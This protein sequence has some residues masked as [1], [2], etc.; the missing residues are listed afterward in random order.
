MLLILQ[1][2][3]SITLPVFIAFI[4]AINATAAPILT[5][6]DPVFNFGIRD[7]A[8]V[9]T[10]SF[11]LSN[12]GDQ[13]LLITETKESCGCTLSE[14]EKKHI[15]P[16][17]HTEIRIM[18]ALKGMAGP[19]KKHVHIISNDPKRVKTITLKGTAMAR[20]A[21]EPP[22]LSMGRINPNSP[23]PPMQVNLTGYIT[24][25]IIT[26]ISCNTNLFR[27]VKNQD[28]RSFTVH[29]PENPPQGACKQQVI[30]KSSDNQS[31][32]LVMSVFAYTTP[33]IRF[34]PR[35]VSV[36][37]DSENAKRWVMLKPGSA[38]RFKLIDTKLSS[39]FASVKVDSRPNS[40][41][42]VVLSEIKPDL[43]KPNSNIT[44]IT[45]NSEQSEIIIPVKVLN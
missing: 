36:P 29:P 8:S 5:I 21:L 3:R 34:V 23:P 9:V 12:T 43:I 13:P 4:A 16:G 10:N 40:S 38:G 26:E 15:P 44:L 33:P 41:Y 42:H 6:K 28:S 14:I 18:M 22:A 35:T 2:G 17:E 24:N 37:K 19:V 45:D 39:P 31:P 27:V 20:V 25:A 7:S 32:K 30:V 11:K 1:R